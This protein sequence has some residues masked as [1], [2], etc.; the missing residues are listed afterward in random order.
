MNDFERHRC[1][2]CY[3]AKAFDSGQKCLQPLNDIS[4]RLTPYDSVAGSSMSLSSLSHLVHVNVSRDHPA[5][6]LEAQ[7]FSI[8]KYISRAIFALIQTDIKS[9][10]RFHRF[11]HT[12]R[13]K[14]VARSTNINRQRHRYSGKKNALG[15]CLSS[16][17]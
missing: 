13:R 5:T 8:I 9:S 12:T 10:D 2:S 17:E 14:K 11:A 1:S 4:Y 15:K 7:N 3:F 16:R 6:V